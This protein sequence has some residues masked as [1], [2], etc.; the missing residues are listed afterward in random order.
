MKSTLYTVSITKNSCSFKKPMIGPYDSAQTHVITLQ[1]SHNSIK[2]FV[3]AIRMNTTSSD[4][5]HSINLINE[6]AVMC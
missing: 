2:R 5:A 4:S 6:C 3:C 1:G